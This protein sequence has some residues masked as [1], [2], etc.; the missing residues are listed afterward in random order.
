M[1]FWIWAHCKRQ[2]T[3]AKCS[4]LLYFKFHHPYTID[5]HTYCTWITESTANLV[6]LPKGNRCVNAQ[7]RH[8]VQ[9][10]TINTRELKFLGDSG[11]IC[12]LAFRESVRCSRGPPV[13][14][15]LVVSN[16]GVKWTA[17]STRHGAARE[18]RGWRSV[19][20]WPQRPPP[21][22][23]SKLLTSLLQLQKT[24]PQNVSLLCSS[25]VTQSRFDKTMILATYS[26]LHFFL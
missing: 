11:H 20:A 26:C 23:S 2:P 7:P 25:S 14:R 9:T 1:L 16:A 13:C 21:M 22:H 15:Q 18:V 12:R 10:L 4:F 8:G 24:F 6:G 17:H 19:S 5:Y 3:P